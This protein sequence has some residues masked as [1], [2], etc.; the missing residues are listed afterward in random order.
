MGRS[1]SSRIQIRPRLGARATGPRV[2]RLRCGCL[3]LAPD[4]ELDRS[5][6]LLVGWQLDCRGDYRLTGLA[7]AFAKSVS[8]CARGLSPTPR[9]QERRRRLVRAPRPEAPR[10]ESFAYRRARDPR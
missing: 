9:L 4:A 10:I 7:L 1:R 2:H 5:R 8:A 6:N 3:P